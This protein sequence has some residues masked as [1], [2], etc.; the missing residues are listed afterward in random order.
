MTGTAEPPNQ[1]NNRPMTQHA[2][3]Q[4]AVLGETVRD[5]ASDVAQTAR[6]QA[7][8]VAHT[9]R[10]ET[11]QVVDRAKD[12]VGHEARQ[13]TDELARSMRRI[14]DGINALAEG[15]PEDAGPVAGY[16]RDAAARVGDM[17]QRLESRGYDGMVQD[18]SAF[19]RRRPG[20]FLAGAGLLGFA[21]GRVI[22]SGGASSSS[23][24]SST[25][26]TS[27]MRST[28]G[29][30]GMQDATVSME[31]VMP[32]PA[33]AAPISAAR[34]GQAMTPGTAGAPRPGG[35]LR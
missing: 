19:A 28:Q 25:G 11:A 16:A 6:E 15:R 9:A 2:A 5:Q 10:E 3:E 31:P 17:A 26:S 32:A 1:G 22:R 13:R 24:G 29:M 20:V 21:V 4:G 14:G 18:V 12:A 7:H 8:D 33:P 35:G 30:Q 23:N 27:G 34:A